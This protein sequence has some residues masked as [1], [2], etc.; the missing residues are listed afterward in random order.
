ME[1]PSSTAQM[2]VLRVKRKLTKEP[3]NALLVHNSVK[4][5]K[6]VSCT[7]GGIAESPPQVFTY[8]G[9]VD[10]DQTEESRNVV[11]NFRTIYQ[12]V[13][14]AG[15]P[16]RGKIKRRKEQE[17]R[18]KF[19][20]FRV[21]SENR[22]LPET[23]EMSELYK[24]YDMISEDDGLECLEINKDKLPENDKILCNNIEMIREKLNIDE[25]KN[26]A[27][28]TENDYVYDL[29]LAPGGAIIIND[30]EIID[31]EECCTNDFDY[32]K[33]MKEDGKE[34]C[35]DDEDD[36]NDEDNWRN[37]YPEDKSDSE[38][39]SEDDCQGHRRRELY[40]NTNR[41]LFEGYSSSD[42]ENSSHA[43]YG[44]YTHETP[45][46]YNYTITDDISDE[47]Y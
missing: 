44:I 22:Q 17:T 35:Y 1:S 9:T 6:Q 2:T 29:Y 25:N 5:A 47:E 11:K 20:R 27:V 14:H 12:Q 31:I 45:N 32:S 18:Q 19:S 7:P 40:D 24:I 34:E 38:S 21:V 23:T 28:S 37:E 16:G 39:D 30:N 4:K 42:D 3:L 43:R 36:E 41:G 10:K 13:H 46:D 26:A 15:D 33:H 8:S